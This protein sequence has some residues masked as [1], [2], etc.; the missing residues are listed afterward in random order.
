MDTITNNEPQQ[1][2]LN[3]FR[4]TANYLIFQKNQNLSVQKRFAC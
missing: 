3:K 4:T 2:Y 1:P